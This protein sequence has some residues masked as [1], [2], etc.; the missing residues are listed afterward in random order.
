MTRKRAERRLNVIELTDKEAAALTTAGNSAPY[1]F[2]LGLAVSKLF[3]DSPPAITL[4]ALRQL[5]EANDAVIASIAR[6]AL[7]AIGDR[8]PADAPEGP[9]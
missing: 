6:E 9:A 2:H 5:A 1:D 8:L 7:E 3:P 4:I